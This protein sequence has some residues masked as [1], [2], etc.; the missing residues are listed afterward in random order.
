M[1]SLNPHDFNADVYK[2][3]KLD[4]YEELSRRSNILN[5]IRGSLIEVAKNIKIESGIMTPQ[6]ADQYIYAIETLK[7]DLS[8]QAFKVAEIRK[9]V[10]SM[11]PGDEILNGESQAFYFISKTHDMMKLIGVYMV[12][13]GKM[14]G[15]LKELK[16][17]RNK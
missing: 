5:G 8:N 4:L 11:Y 13:A 12:E 6:K 3:K 1:H 15:G 17:K 2:R 14:I 10:N 7:N 16:R 9:A